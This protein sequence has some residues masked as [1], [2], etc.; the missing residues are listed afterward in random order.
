MLV[1]LVGHEMLM[2]SYNEAVTNFQQCSPTSSRQLHD[3]PNINPVCCRV[4]I[5]V[6][7]LDSENVMFQIQKT[8]ATHSSESLG[9]S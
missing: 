4:V 1:T 9:N 5:P 2:T 8:M 6:N 7:F 3:F